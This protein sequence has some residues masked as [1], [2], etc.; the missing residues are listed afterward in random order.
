MSQRPGASFLQEEV[1]GLY[2]HRPPYPQELFDL[3]VDLSPRQN[4]LLDLGC[5]HGKIARPMS[6][7]FAEV[8]AIDPS[9]QMISLGQSLP[10]GT[11]SNLTWVESYAE[12]A[13]LTGLYDTVTAALSIHWMDHKRL[14]AKLI[15]HLA[16]DYL[17]TVIEG[18]APLNPPWEKDWQAFLR[19][20]V[21]RLTGNPFHADKRWPFWERYA[22]HATLQ[23][24]YE[25]ISAPFTQ[26]IEDFIL[27]QHSRDT[28]ALSKMSTHGDRFDD[29]LRRLLTPYAN[30]VGMLE[31]QTYTKLTVVTI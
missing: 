13:P 18:D 21:P 27:C 19:E 7:H 6:E 23:D 9:A 2:L 31:F 11:A 26:S 3:L 30:A 12:D 10:N 24:K 5:G 16:Q 15:P 17:F 1:V 14:F 25:I 28:F 29:A 4:R 8:T 20:W 22:D